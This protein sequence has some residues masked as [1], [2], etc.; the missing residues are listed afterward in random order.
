MKTTKEGE[1]AN[2]KFQGV[3]KHQRWQL[4]SLPAFFSANVQTLLRAQDGV[5]SSRLQRQLEEP[6]E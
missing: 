6:G 1:H 5:R 3:D 4:L 2:T